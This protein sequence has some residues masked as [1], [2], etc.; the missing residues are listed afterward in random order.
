MDDFDLDR[1]LD[2]LKQRLDEDI[3]R[4]GALDRMAAAVRS[5]M[6]ER[7]PVGRSLAGRSTVAGGLRARA[8][9]A[10]TAAALIAACLAGVAVGIALPAPEDQADLSV[11]SLDALT[12]G[13]LEGFEP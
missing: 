3:A 7:A 4:S 5:G 1:A 2:G 13:P 10:R 12:F 11:S 9:R 8:A 6:A